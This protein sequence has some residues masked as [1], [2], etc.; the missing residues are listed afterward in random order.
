MIPFCIKMLLC[1]WLLFEYKWEIF[2]YKFL[3]STIKQV[4]ITKW[5]YI[6]N[7]I[8]EATQCHHEENR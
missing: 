4:N 1:E 3:F 2:F 8:A 6:L 7:T 5:V